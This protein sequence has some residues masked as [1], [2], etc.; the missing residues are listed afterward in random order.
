M[1]PARLRRFHDRQEPVAGQPV[2]LP[3]G[4][5]ADPPGDD[6]KPAASHPGAVALHPR[7]YGG[8]HPG[9]FAVSRPAAHPEGSFASHRTLSAFDLWHRRGG[10]PDP[11]GT[12]QGL[13]L[14]ALGDAATAGLRQATGTEAGLL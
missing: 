13:E 10:V 3:V 8:L 1:P 4:Q 12:G 7:L 14:P 6:P 11:K 2:R 9:Q 5:Q